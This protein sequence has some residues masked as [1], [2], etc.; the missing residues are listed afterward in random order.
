MEVMSI[1]GKVYKDAKIL[2][3]YT[4]ICTCVSH[5]DKFVVHKENLPDLFPNFVRR[6]PYM[7]SRA[8][9]THFDLL[10]TQRSADNTYGV[11]RRGRHI[12]RVG[13]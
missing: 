7:S 3:E 12:S 8:E 2:R 4:N 10:E 1:Y 6:R 5:G 13:R 9:S 11:A